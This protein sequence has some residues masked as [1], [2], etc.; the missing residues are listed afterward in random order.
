[1]WYMF[2]RKP[3][4]ALQNSCFFG[5]IL[6]ADLHP[7]EKGV[8][9][10]NSLLAL[11]QL[12]SLQRRATACALT[13]PF[14]QGNLSTW[15]LLNWHPTRTRLWGRLRV[16]FFQCG[17]KSLEMLEIYVTLESWVILTVKSHWTINI[18]AKIF[19]P[20]SLLDDFRTT[21]WHLHPLCLIA[22]EQ[23]AYCSR[24]TINCWSNLGEERPENIYFFRRNPFRGRIES[25]Q[26]A[27]KRFPKVALQTYPRLFLEMLI[28]CRICISKHAN[29]WG[30][31]NLQLLL[32]LTDFLCVCLFV[33]IKP[34]K[35]HFAFCVGREVLSFFHSFFLWFGR[36]KPITG[37]SGWWTP[38]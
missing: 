8:P 26:S 10:Q 28:S 12:V 34:A 37:L 22:A 14:K 5:N 27:G 6:V 1:M 29:L 7:K 17:V 33:G 32:I 36:P 9:I 15:S 35:P 13:C 16:V 24:G 4:P 3:I 31:T 38:D 11:C 21:L 30:K 18:S 23:Y 19:W 20:Q 25:I 2:K